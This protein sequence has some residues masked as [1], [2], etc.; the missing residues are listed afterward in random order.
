[1][2][3]PTLLLLAAGMGS[4]YG[5]LKQIDPVG[6]AGETI[7]DYSIYD[8][9]RAGFGKVVFVIRKDIEI[10]FREI[11]GAR[12]EE[13]IA[14][15]YVFQEL[16]NVPPGFSVPV[17]RTRPWGTMHAILMA[18]DVV[19]EPFAVIN[20]DDF[21]GAESYHI[22]AKYLQC[23]AED[24]AM[25]GYVLR[26]TLS[27]FGAVARGVC[28][29]SDDDMLQS[30]VELTRIERDGAAAKN[31]DPTGQ[32]TKLTGAEIVSMNMWGF[33]PRV[34][35]QL[36][37]YFQRFL[38]LQGS[39]ISAESYIPSAV[40]KLILAGQA[41][42]KVLRTSDA[43]LG[44]TYREDRLRVVKGISQLIDDGYYPKELWS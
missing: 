44:I 10:P 37:E 11:V 23:G 13:R 1:M 17:G 8:A 4:R 35:E 9:I 29:V 19:R 27:D 38:E 41:R 36:R 20:A 24:Y 28:H 21:Y 30:V 3:S 12:F 26:N 7:M 34:F 25:A 15:E 33:T 2:T 18:A 16:A 40:N 32:V 5:G 42:V 31:S 39:N 43:W 6:P 22:L 14:V